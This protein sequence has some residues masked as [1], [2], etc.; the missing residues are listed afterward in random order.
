MR[1][2][3]PLIPT[4][5]TAGALIACSDGLAPPEATTGFAVHPEFAVVDASSGGAAHFHFLPPL[6]AMPAT[7]GIFDSTARP[8]VE[9]CVVAHG[10]CGEVV[11]VYDADNGLSAEAEDYSARWATGTLDPSLYGSLFRIRVLVHG[12]PL[13]HADVLVLEPGRSRPADADTYGVHP[14]QPV[15]IRF[16]IEEPD[17]IYLDARVLTAP[18]LVVPGVDRV[19]TAEPV[20]LPIEPGTHEVVY[21]TSGGEKVTGPLLAYARAAFDVLEDGTV[22]YDP[23]LDGI[24]SGRGTRALRVTGARLVLDARHLAAPQFHLGGVPGR[25]STTGPQT[26]NLLPG[27]HPI[28]YQTAP[29]GGN[30]GPGGPRYAD[31]YFTARAD[32]TVDYDPALGTGISKGRGIL[33][34]R[35]T[36]TLTITGAVILFRLNRLSADEVHLGGVGRFATAGKWLVS[37]LPGYHPIVYQT[38]AG[39]GVTGPGPAYADAFFF[40]R[41]DGSIDYDDPLEPVLAGRGSSTLDVVGVTLDLDMTALAAPGVRIGG[42]PERRETDSPQTVTLLPGPHRISYQTGLDPVAYTD[43]YFRATVDGVG[44]YDPPLEGVLVGSGTTALAVRGVPITIDATA[45]EESDYLLRGVGTLPTAPDPL[46][47]RLLPGPHQLRTADGDEDFFFHVLPDGT[48]D[49]AAEHDV[50]LRGR[51]TGT[52][53]VLES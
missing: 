32:G 29:S 45:L 50:L 14:G 33:A 7:T 36:D 46:T 1:L 49:Y 16:R 10:R 12:A 19:A 2:P 51:G 9:V 30:T 5:I 52:L 35:G 38:A 25:F 44:E 20:F 22:D 24:F 4:A 42:L 13:G 18:E 17:G 15:L 31:A 21:Q 27:P 40:V 34:G 53:T 28:T 43:A 48:V 23:A 8:V 47:I 37:L 41:P 3:R 6:A 26:V 39:P 11:A